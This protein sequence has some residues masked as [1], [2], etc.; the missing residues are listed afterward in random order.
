MRP[1]PFLSNKLNAMSAALCAQNVNVCARKLCKCKSKVRMAHRLQMSSSQGGED[2]WNSTKAAKIKQKYQWRLILACA[3]HNIRIFAQK[4][5]Q[6]CSKALDR[7]T[8]HTNNTVYHFEW[9][10]FE[11]KRVI[12]AGECRNSSL[13]H[14]HKMNTC[15]ISWRANICEKAVLSR[16]GL[17]PFASMNTRRIIST[18]RVRHW[19]TIS[20]IR[21]SCWMSTA[22]GGGTAP[23]RKPHCPIVNSAYD[24]SKRLNI[25]KIRF[26]A[27]MCSDCTYENNT[28]TVHQSTATV[29]YS[30]FTQAYRNK[31]F[32]IPKSKLLNAHYAGSESMEQTKYNMQLGS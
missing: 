14:G 24:R 13:M 22:V 32:I 3:L 16:C 1:V 4:I 12:R 17:L 9:G 30:F 29:C 15:G 5:K 23:R 6:N 8:N 26:I 31:P 18:S 10:S 20:L 7:E 11:G 19:S 28:A 25:C 21:S 2:S 27:Q